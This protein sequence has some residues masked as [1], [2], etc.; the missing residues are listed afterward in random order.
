[1]TLP[2][3]GSPFNLTLAKDSSYAILT[4]RTFGRNRVKLKNRS[5]NYR[6]F[7]RWVFG[8]IKEKDIQ[9]LVIDIRGN[10]GGFE[11]F[12][13]YLFGHLADTTFRKYEFVAMR[14]QKFSK[15]RYTSAPI[16]VK[17][18]SM[19]FPLKY[20][21][22]NDTLYIRKDKS[23]YNNYFETKKSIRDQFTGDVY[24]LI[25]GKVFS[26]ASEFATLIKEYK[27][28]IL[29]GTETGGGYEGNT[30][31]HYLPLVL[32]NSKVRASIPVMWYKMKV[33]AGHFGEGIKPDIKVAQDT[34]K[35]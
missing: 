8:E 18:A 6:K 28:G 31:G 23:R 5:M 20:T 21:K 11:G 12:E 32:P 4:L 22:Q 7:I 16:R 2:K 9:N 15:P 14:T 30:S 10:G 34:R 29:I 26:A 24:V 19:Y 33:E 27:K 35:T 3:Q 17:L 1:M 25:D 13:D